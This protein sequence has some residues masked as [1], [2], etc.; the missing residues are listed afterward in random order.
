MDSVLFIVHMLL[1]YEIVL[2]L[3]N[4]SSISYSIQYLLTFE[5]WSW[6]GAGGEELSIMQPIIALPPSI[7]FPLGPGP[8][9]CQSLHCR[10]VP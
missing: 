5:K 7:S 9:G 10:Y 4:K 2:F 1:P 3:S 6:A 8:V